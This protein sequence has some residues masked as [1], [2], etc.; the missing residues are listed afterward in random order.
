MKKTSRWAEFRDLI[1]QFLPIG[2]QSELSEI[3]GM[4]YFGISLTGRTYSKK[5]KQR[6]L[7]E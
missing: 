6:H 3:C 7:N 4:P 5:K 2:D 1:G